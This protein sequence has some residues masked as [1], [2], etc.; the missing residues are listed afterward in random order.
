M[1][2][3]QYKDPLHIPQSE[4]VIEYDEPEQFIISKRFMDLTK[5]WKNLSKLKEAYWW[6]LMFFD[7]IKE[8]DDLLELHSLAEDLKD[9]EMYIQELFN[10]TPDPNYHRFWEA[11][12]C[13]CPKTDN[14]ERWGTPYTIVN[15]FCVL[16]GPMTRS[17]MRRLTIIGRGK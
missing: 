3:K 10:F 6:K 7:M 14:S 4:L 8:T 2:R 16:H 9:L 11:P 17:E 15:H 12:K 1:P 13:S 5:A